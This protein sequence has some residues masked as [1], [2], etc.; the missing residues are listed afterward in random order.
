MWNLV[1][2][3]GKGCPIAPCT[4]Q[5]QLLGNLQGMLYT[6]NTVTGSTT[7]N[8]TVFY[9]EWLREGDGHMHLGNTHFVTPEPG[10]LAL[11]GTGLVGIASVVRRK[12]L[13]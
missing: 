3:A 4:Y 9:G 5:F 10:T 13:S 2:D 7:Q 1:S 8:V 12:L 6:G 11:L